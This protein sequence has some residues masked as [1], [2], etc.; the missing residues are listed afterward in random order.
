M[1]IE[2]TNSEDRIII[3]LKSGMRLSLLEMGKNW[4]IIHVLKRNGEEKGT[5]FWVGATHRVDSPATITKAILVNISSEKLELPQ[6]PSIYPH[7]L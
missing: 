2:S 4:A 6:A 3:E 1:K 5:E 7:T